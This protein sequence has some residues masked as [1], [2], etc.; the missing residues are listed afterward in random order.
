MM[1][2]LLLSVVVTNVN[3]VYNFDSLKCICNDCG[4]KWESEKWEWKCTRCN[5]NNID[6]NVM[7]R[8][9]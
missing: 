8:G 4:N 3:N 7:M 5:S 2:H 9:L 6:Q 1:L